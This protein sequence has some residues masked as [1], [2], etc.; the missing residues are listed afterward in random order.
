MLQTYIMLLQGIVEGDFAVAMSLYH[1]HELLNQHGM[2]PFYNFF[3]KKDEGDSSSKRINQV[4]HRF[5]SKV[6]I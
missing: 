5:F 3:T 4:F 2:R 6:I 1:G